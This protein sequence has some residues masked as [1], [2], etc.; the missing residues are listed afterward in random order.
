M[1]ATFFRGQEVSSDIRIETPYRAIQPITRGLPPDVEPSPIW[2]IRPFL[3]YSA[4]SLREYSKVLEAASD[5]I[6]TAQYRLF[7]E[8]LIGACDRVAQVEAA[9]RQALDLKTERISNEIDQ[10]TPKLVVLRE[11]EEAE[12]L[13][14]AAKVSEAGF[15]FDPN[16]SSLDATKHP[17][18][19][20]A[21]LCADLKIPV[22]DIEPSWL[23][24][25]G[26]RLLSTFVIGAL[27][28]ILIGQLLGLSEWW[29][30][31]PSI[32][33]GSTLML[34]A[35]V[36]GL[37]A[38][39]LGFARAQAE[40]ARSARQET[41]WSY[42]DTLTVSFTCFLIIEVCVEQYGFMRALT[43]STSNQSYVPTGGA[44]L[45][46]ALAIAF[47][48]LVATALGNLFEGV[49]QS[50]HNLL[51]QTHAKRLAEIRTSVAFVQAQSAQA[52][53]HVARMYRQQLEAK[54][55]KLAGSL[56]QELSTRD[57]EWIGELERTA[58]GASWD[59]QDRF[60]KPSP[61]PDD[62]PHRPTRRT[63][64]CYRLALFIRKVLR[65]RNPPNPAIHRQKPTT[66]TQSTGG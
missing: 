61:T 38:R 49:R 7:A 6:T 4:V 51:A 20:R 46:I 29:Q 8:N 34:F 63:C 14:A 40:H 18:L 44:F 62:Q 37:P 16:A 57:R 22:P 48:T 12:L 56:S 19:D 64:C 59:L 35:T 17:D 10:L 5:P 24:T 28:G 31:V 66:Q 39:H 50:H 23:W 27:Y 33:V 36:I 52:A 65:G 60:L 41:G 11:A 43:E 9:C 54:I 2:Y 21:A 15:A 1:S 26:T 30:V 45:A 32:L 55:S 58:L 25:K 53:L 3:G 47:P 13:A 42:G